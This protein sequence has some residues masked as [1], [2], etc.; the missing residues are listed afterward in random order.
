M[1]LVLI[2]G[3]EN[4]RSATDGALRE[5]ARNLVGSRYS[6]LA[7]ENLITLAHLAVSSAMIFPKSPGGAMIG[8]PPSSTIRDLIFGSA[9]AVLISRLSFPMISGGVFFGAVRPFQELAS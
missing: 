5:L 8:G 7:P 6:A 3:M 4:Q 2:L 9:I 1:S